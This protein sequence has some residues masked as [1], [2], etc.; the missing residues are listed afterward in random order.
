MLGVTSWE[1]YK[2]CILQMTKSKSFQ[3]TPQV[4]TKMLKLL[5]IKLKS[6]PLEEYGM[7]INYNTISKRRKWKKFRKTVE[8]SFSYT[9][10]NPQYEAHKAFILQML[11]SEKFGADSF[12]R[13]GMVLRTNLTFDQTKFIIGAK[14]I[15]H[16]DLSRLPPDFHKKVDNKDTF[17]N[18]FHQI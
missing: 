7:L 1:E 9:S 8:E 11:R 18:I 13:Y 12:G 14:N 5:T 10:S 2:T 3:L 17:N 16:T 4:F 15:E 6:S